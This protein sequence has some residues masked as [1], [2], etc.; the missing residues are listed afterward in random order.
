[1]AQRAINLTMGY[2]LDCHKAKKASTECI[3]CHY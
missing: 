3:A 1:V 2:C